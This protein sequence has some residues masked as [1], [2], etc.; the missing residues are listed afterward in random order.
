MKRFALT[1]LPV[2]FAMIVLAQGE[3]QLNIRLYPLQTI[4]VKQNLFSDHFF[5]NIDAFGTT[6]YVVKR[7]DGWE[8]ETNVQAAPTKEDPIMSGHA[9]IEMEQYLADVLYSIEPL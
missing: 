3:V 1:L 8:Q 9:P 7:L 6:R 4:E 2:L 5:D